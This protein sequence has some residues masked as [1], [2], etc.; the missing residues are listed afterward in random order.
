[1]LIDDIC[2]FLYVNCCMYMYMYEERT[3]GMIGYPI[4]QS[5]IN[6]DIIITITDEEDFA[7]LVK[8]S[9]FQKKE[10]L[11][12]RRVFSLKVKLNEVEFLEV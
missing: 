3:S 5:S 10:L 9:M 1:M 7:I 2:L 4:E 8:T 11:C 6:K 12:L